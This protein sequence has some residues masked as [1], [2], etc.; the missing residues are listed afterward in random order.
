MAGQGGHSPLFCLRNILSEICLL[1]KLR[2]ILNRNPF[3]AGPGNR[4][5]SFYS[6]FWVKKGF[7]VWSKTK[8]FMKEVDCSPGPKYVWDI[9]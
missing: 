4:N 3:I 9:Q 6:Q 8:N 5:N 2:A 1:R 7:I